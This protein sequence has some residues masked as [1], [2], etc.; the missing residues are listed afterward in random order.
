MDQNLSSLFL[1]ELTEKAVTISSARLFR[2]FVILLQK[3]N[4]V[5]RFIA[6]MG[7]HI[8]NCAL[9]LT[10]DFSPSSVT[11]KRVHALDGLQAESD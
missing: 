5:V 6:V 1:K 10:I 11:C 2:T 3:E 9:L 8:R 7:P 4:D